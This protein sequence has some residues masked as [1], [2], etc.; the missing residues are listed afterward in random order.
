V[1]LVLQWTDGQRGGGVLNQLR[2]AVAS[3]G[4]SFLAAVVVVAV[5]AVGLVFIWTLYHIVSGAPQ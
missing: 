3:S 4:A 1:L 2:L 5:T